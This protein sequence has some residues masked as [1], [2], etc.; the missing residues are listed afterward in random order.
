MYEDYGFSAGPNGL[1][2]TLRDQISTKGIYVIFSVF[3]SL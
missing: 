1:N 2:D 3:F